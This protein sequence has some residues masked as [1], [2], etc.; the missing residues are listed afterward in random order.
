MDDYI[1][2]TIDIYDAVADSFAKQALDHVPLEQRK[3]FVSLLPKSGKILDVGCGSGRDSSYFSDLG[4]QV[5]GVDLSEKLLE[6]AR[7]NDPKTTFICA[8]IRHLFFENVL[9]DGLWSCAS[10]LHIKHNE[11]LETLRSWQR[12]LKTA[13]ILFIHVKKG[14]GEI[15]KEEPSVPGVK[16]LYSL[17]SKDQLISYCERSGFTV[18]SCYE[19]MGSKRN[20]PTDSMWIDCFAQK[21]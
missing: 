13:G 15:E 12:L 2:K 9:F 10:L 8:D 4:F 20:S 3:H 6:I 5:I 18:L 14:E 11:V 19:I 21:V 17:F 1:Q 16:R 7:I